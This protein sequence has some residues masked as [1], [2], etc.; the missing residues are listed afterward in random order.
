LVRRTYGVG[1]AKIEFEHS[2]GSG[3]AVTSVTLQSTNQ[4][5]QAPPSDV[6]YFPLAKGKT[7]TY[8]WTNTKHLTKPE[9]ERFTTDAVANGSA[10]F[11]VKS[12][13]G[14]IK[15]AGTYG[16]SK[17]LDG[18]TN[19]WGTTQSATQLKFPALGPRSASSAD[20][21]HIVTPFDLMTFGMNPIL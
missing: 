19:L 4:T 6:D 8:R 7:L 1:P 17:R 10:R 15:V 12:V 5:A 18:I 21:N 11:T 16:F 3:A 14:P 20:R 13:S 2:G 9:V